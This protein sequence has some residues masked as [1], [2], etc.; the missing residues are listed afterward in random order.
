VFDSTTTK[1]NMK[2]D[3][4]TELALA[5]G[6]KLKAQPDGT[7]AL[8]PYVFDFARAIIGEAQ[9]YDQTALELCAICGWKAV[10]P[11]ECCLNCEHEKRENKS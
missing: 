6:F 9:K 4:I 10:I 5:N 7:E 11:D 3:R 8:N 2:K 1:A